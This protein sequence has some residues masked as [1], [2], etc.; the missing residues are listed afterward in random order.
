MKCGPLP[1]EI[2][3]QKVRH[4]PVA[5]GE[6]EKLHHHLTI[7]IDFLSEDLGIE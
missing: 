5:V 1:A 3:T 2:E 7:E 6:D 4:Q